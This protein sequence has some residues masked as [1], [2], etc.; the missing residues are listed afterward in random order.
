M[1]TQISLAFSMDDFNASM[2]YAVARGYHKTGIGNPVMALFQNNDGTWI[3]VTASGSL[4]KVEARTKGD[5]DVYR[6]VCSEAAKKTA[7]PIH[8]DVVEASKLDLQDLASVLAW[9]EVNGPRLHESLTRKTVAE[10]AF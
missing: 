1:S 6:D 9:A 7:I 8:A 2:E 5:E 4:E 10:P 3:P